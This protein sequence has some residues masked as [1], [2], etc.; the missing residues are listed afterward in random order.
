M[1]GGKLI[2]RYFLRNESGFLIIIFAMVFMSV[3]VFSFLDTDEPKQKM[4]MSQFRKNRL[5]K[6]E[7]S[8]KSKATELVKK[9]SI[10]VE[11]KDTESDNTG[12]E[13]QDQLPQSIHSSRI[14][15]RNWLEKF[16][17][18]KPKTVEKAVDDNDKMP[19]EIEPEV[20]Q[21]IDKNREINLTELSKVKRKNKNKPETYAFDEVIKW[22]SEAGWVM[23]TYSGEHL[24]RDKKNV[25]SYFT[26]K[27]WQVVSSALFDDAKSP[28]SK[29]G[30]TKGTTRA[31]T[32]DWPK[33]LHMDVGERGK[34]WWLKVPVMVVIKESGVIKRAFYEISL[35]VL[36]NDSEEKRQF[37]ADDVVIKL[38]GVDEKKAKK[39][40]KNAR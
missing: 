1:A 37:I 19:Y 36:S 25:A 2:F 17:T 15:N 24:D 33:S 26:P 39:R 16:E 23:L 13:E 22:T 31:M 40:G 32:V 12:E 3:D 28:L 34:M 29:L 18:K 20:G 27:A 14:L 30:Q 21:K 10:Q 6:G 11:N 9:A 4:V 35:G 8:K 5:S 38:V 7:E